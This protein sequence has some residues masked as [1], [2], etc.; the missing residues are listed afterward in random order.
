MM[1]NRIA[2]LKN[3]LLAAA[4]MLMT[5]SAWGA[6]SV[7]IWPINPVLK[8]DE[9][10]TALWLEN[11]GAQEVT[12]QV[13]VFAWGQESGDIYSTQNEIMASPPVFTV[14]VG[15]KQLIRLTKTGNVQAGVENA[16]RVIVDEVP[17]KDKV[18]SDQ[19][20]ALKFQ[21]RYSVPLFVYGTGK[22][23]LEKKGSDAQNLQEG[24]SLSWRIV[25]NMLEISNASDHHV[26]LTGA[27]VVNN[28]KEFSLENGLL[29]YV[30][31]N[32]SN[33]WPLPA[34]LNGQSIL[35]GQVNGGE[36]IVIKKY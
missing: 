4:M 25:D 12:L 3:C 17:V 19:G 32:S 33:R 35:K 23:P 22:E 15:E 27:S 26:R 34:G 2:G 29:G 6:A 16:Y 5:A 36:A 24:Q 18:S 8:A 31:G 7:Q 30:L 20:S 9:N 28:G 14:P 21:M 1:R 11:R 10:A 13:R